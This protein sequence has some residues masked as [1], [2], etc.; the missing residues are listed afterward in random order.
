MES[1]GY[2]LVVGSAN[3]DVSVTARE[4]PQPGQTVIG[5]GAVI[6]VGGKG[7]NQAAAAAGCG[8]TTQFVACV[9]GDAFGRMVR[10]ELGARGI[11]VD[12]IREQPDA[13]TGLAAIY[14]DHAGQ[15]CIVV[16]PGANARL[17]P[18]DIDES[19]ALIRG[20]SVVVVQCEIPAETVYRTIELAA[21]AN[22]LV[23]LNP[24]PAGQIEVARLAGRVGYLVPNETEASQ[25]TGFRVES[26][27]DA[28]RC[29]TLLQSGGID[30]VVITLGSRGCI[31]ADEV[32]VRHIPAHCVAA[33]DA[34]GAGD[35][36]V[37]CLAASLAAGLSREE[38]IRKAVVYSALSTTKRGALVSYLTG[39]AARTLPALQT[40]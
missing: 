26:V 18:V 7:A 34:T 14:V 24:A 21:K 40:N 30:C 19:L 33:I 1:D 13:T 23:I 27:S 37:G 12:S 3:M 16:V 5:D 9:G 29:A 20:A 28:E 22:K 35:A 15:N 4:L 11:S 8:A 2:V 6:G 36:F 31:V 10:S 39:D 25:L 32:G 17:A 38:S